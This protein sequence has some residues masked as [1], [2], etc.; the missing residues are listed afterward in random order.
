MWNHF[1]TR[2]G[3]SQ[4]TVPPYCRDRG[5]NY[6]PDQYFNYQPHVV[7]SQFRKYKKRYLPELDIFNFDANLLF[8]FLELSQKINL[9]AFKNRAD[10]AAGNKFTGQYRFRQRIF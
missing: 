6:V 3:E 8:S 10:C 5:C 7:R 1:S 4:Y 9:I 2:N